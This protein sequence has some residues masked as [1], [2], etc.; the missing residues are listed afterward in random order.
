MAWLTP[1]SRGKVPRVVGY[2]S[3]DGKVISI[4][5]KN[6]SLSN[7]QKVRDLVCLLEE[8]KRYGQSPTPEEIMKCEVLGAR[9]C[10]RLRAGGLLPADPE[11]GMRVSD[12]TRSW[13]NKKY[14]ETESKNTLGIYRRECKRL[15]MWFGERLVSSLSVQDAETWRDNRYSM[16]N[17]TSRYM[18]GK[19]YQRCRSIM[20]YAITLGAIN[21]NP[22]PE[23][24]VKA[25]RHLAVRSKEYV[26]RETC[27]QV[28][29]ACND[30]TER[31]LFA[32]GRFGGLRHASEFRKLEWSHVDFEKKM[33]TVVRTKT[34][35][36]RVPIYPEIRPFI[37]AER[38]ANPEAR[39]VVPVRRDKKAGREPISK[40]QM[41]EKLRHGVERSGAKQWP[42]L[43]Q[44]LRVSA[45][46]DRIRAG[47]ALPMLN[48][49][50]GNSDDVRRLHYEMSIESDYDR[51]TEGPALRWKE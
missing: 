28:F 33:I 38:T 22:F 7:G 35:E 23:G 46:N 32:L 27:C 39:F 51:V 37:L 49:V 9:I 20:G 43:W 11:T 8:R 3:K 10:N 41:D 42:S 12:L 36:R 29:R 47:D 4:S 24:F 21:K 2:R 16:P 50:F 6:C 17:V 44:S 48:A 40:F 45:I 18:V 25:S 34:K 19:E 15:E 13:M 30:N 14:Q 26:D 1:K 31:L 5:L